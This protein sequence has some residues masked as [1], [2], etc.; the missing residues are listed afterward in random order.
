MLWYFFDLLSDY[1]LLSYFMNKIDFF[2]LKLSAQQT[3]SEQRMQYLHQL[4]DMMLVPNFALW[5]VQVCY[6]FIHSQE[7]GGSV[8]SRRNPW[9]NCRCC[10]CCSADST[11][12]NSGG[13]CDS[14]KK[15]TEIQEKQRQKLN[16]FAT[17]RKKGARFR[18]TIMC[19]YVRIFF[20]CVNFSRYKK[21]HKH[22]TR[23]KNEQTRVW[24]SS[25]SSSFFTWDVCKDLLAPQHKESN[26]VDRHPETKINVL[27]HCNIAKCAWL[28]FIAF[29]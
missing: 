26:I 4:L 19:E 20:F 16:A 11:S 6:W 24:T 27:L 29:H 3:C 10:C 23:E 8:S 12:D 15:M 21:A 2:Q 5:F 13:V 18:H 1:V 9:T 25:S 7:S 17:L 22:G 28:E 14:W